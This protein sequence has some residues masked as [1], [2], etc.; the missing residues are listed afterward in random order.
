M[1]APTPSAA[2][3]IDGGTDF[4]DAR[5]AIIIVGKVIRVRTIPPTTGVDLGEALRLALVAKERFP[6]DPNISDTLGY[7]HY[8]RDAFDLATTQFR[9][10]LTDLPHVP[11]IRYHLALSL[12][13]EGADAEAL[14]E[15]EIALQD[16]TAFPEEEEAK[17]LLESWKLF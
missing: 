8:K 6:D 4:N 5:L 15:L 12:K 7:I 9:Q 14:K 2:S 3:R 1:E 11:T 13:G 17:K 16:G 10:A